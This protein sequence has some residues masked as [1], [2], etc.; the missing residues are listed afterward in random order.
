[1]LAVYIQLVLAVYI[2]RVMVVYIQLVAYTQ[3]VLASD[4]QLVLASYKQ[5]YWSHIQY[6]L[7]QSVLAKQHYKKLTIIVS[8]YNL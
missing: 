1:V 8:S 6:W 4:I 2:Q 7:Q 3:L 5:P